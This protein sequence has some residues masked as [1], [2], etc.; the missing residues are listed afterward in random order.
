MTKQDIITA[1]QNW[2]TKYGSSY[3]ELYV[4]I[5]SNIDQRLFTDHGVNKVDIWIHAPADSNET[6]R[7]VEKYFLDTGCDGDTGGGD[8]FSTR[9][10]AYKKNSHTNP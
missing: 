2:I 9:V 10:Y 1:F 7:S 6:A 3:N 8:Y 4:G 5:T